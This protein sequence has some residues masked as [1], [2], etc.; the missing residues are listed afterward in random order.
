M[1]EPL[2]VPVKLSPTTSD[3]ISKDIIEI[4]GLLA[5]RDGALTLEYRTL[6][7]S[8]GKSS[9]QLVRI[10]LQ[11]LREIVMKKQL[12]KWTITVRPTEMSIIEGIPGAENHS[13]NMKVDRKFH[14]DGERL[15][16]FVG[17][18][19][20][21][22]RLNSLAPEILQELGHAARADNTRV[23]EQWTVAA[24][25][26]SGPGADQRNEVA[27]VLRRINNA[28]LGN[29]PDDLA[30]IAHENMVMVYPGFAGRAEGRE[31]IV[32]GFAEFLSQARVTMYRESDLQIDVV[33]DTAVATFAYE[34]TYERD[35][36]TYR[37]TGRDMWIFGKHGG[38]WLAVWHAM[39][40][41][42]EEEAGEEDKSP[43]N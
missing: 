20:S 10:A 38:E 17:L 30:S 16:S 25:G 3:I 33:G 15:V 32:A 31:Q 9:V 43:K 7:M 29:R 5:Y 14:E 36:G 23:A 4:D 35:G 21:E 24:P 6:S 19:L 1:L 39:L 13:L 12:L 42:R 34:M 26:T 11:D 37:T 2:S 28:W 8:M 18:E 27:A 41:M 40:D 22:F